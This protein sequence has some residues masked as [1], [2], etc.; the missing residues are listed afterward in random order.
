MWSLCKL[1]VQYHC[2]NKSL[3]RS[4]C[5]NSLPNSF[6]VYFLFHRCSPAPFVEK[7]YSAPSYNAYY[8]HYPNTHHRAPQTGG[9]PPQYKVSAA[10]S[11]G[12]YPAGQ[13][14]A[15]RQYANP[16]KNGAY[17][18]QQQYFRRNRPTDSFLHEYQYSQERYP[19]TRARPTRSL[20]NEGAYYRSVDQRG[21]NHRSRTPDPPSR[22]TR[23]R[24]HVL[25]DD[26]IF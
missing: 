17:Q 13:V 24:R 12:R 16:E 25:S 19:E 4:H 18:Q 7:P 26:M 6:T 10:Q 20:G 5:V 14:Y 21:R 11:E 23:G 1:V 22:H 8:R 2:T 15:T 9:A 3:Y